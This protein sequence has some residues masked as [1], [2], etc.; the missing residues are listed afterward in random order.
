MSSDAPPSSDSASISARDALE[1]A[2]RDEMLKLYGVLVV[3]WVGM[4]V[5][6]FAI[7]ARN[8]F[9]S[10]VGIFVVLGSVVA[11]LVGVVAI[12][13]KLLVEAS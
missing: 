12:A 7:S 9:V 3:G 11:F 5:G 6:Q 4:L 10:F 8:S 1:Y 13:R 2:T